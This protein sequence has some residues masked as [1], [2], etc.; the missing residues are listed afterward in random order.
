MMD[1]EIKEITDDYLSGRLDRRSFFRRMTAV[2]GSYTLVHHYLEVSGL[3]AG[4]IAR[5]E[6]ELA[7]VETREVHYPS[8]EH[9]ILASLSLHS[10]GES[11]PAVVVIHENRGLN[12][13][14]RDVARRFAVAGYVAIAPD[15]LSRAGGTAAAGSP[16]GAR[17]VIR[18]ISWQD[19]TA[20]MIAARTYLQGLPEV[21]GHKVGSVGFC[22]G[23]AR[24]FRFA[25]SDPELSAAVVFYGS[26]P[27]EDLLDG[28]RCPILGLYGENDTRVT[29]T[30]EAT[31]AQMEA[32][33]KSYEP[34]IYP[35]AEHAF[36]NDTRADRHDP[37][38]SADAWQRVLRFFEVH[39]TP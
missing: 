11:A 10:G 39:L 14:T 33:G 12:E 9:S 7:S 21:S 38:A 26:P 20:D 24:S 30:V 4:P 13:H 28:I 35:G 22:W 3:A 25:T 36:F 17:Q 8:G 23:G 19:V 2:L 29:S 31:R 16:D 5:R 18:R 15:F 32:R 34:V 27:P 1:Q 6:A 37:E